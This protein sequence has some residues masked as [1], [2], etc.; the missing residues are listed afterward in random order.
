MA[1]FTDIDMGRSASIRAL[2]NVNAFSDTVHGCEEVLIEA[3]ADFIDFIS[4][5]KFSDA[6]ENNLQSVSEMNDGS[7]VFL[8][9]WM[10]IAD[11]REMISGYDQELV[12]MTEKWQSLGANE[13]QIDGFL[14]RST[15]V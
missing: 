2:K 7:G 6:I 11:F 12:D 10:N 15:A 14:K 13:V 1:K 5:S 8:S 9:S 4:L 3:T